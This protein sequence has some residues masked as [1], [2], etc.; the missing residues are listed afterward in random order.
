MNSSPKAE[1]PGEGAV[2][3]KHRPVCLWGAGSE[4]SRCCPGPELTA[5]SLRC[6]LCLQPEGKERRRAGQAAGDLLAPRGLQPVRLQSGDW[7]SLLSLSGVTSR[8]GGRVSLASLL[9]C[10]LRIQAQSRAY[11]GD[12]LLI[13]T[14]SGALGV[15]VHPSSNQKDKASSLPKEVARAVVPAVPSV[16]R[17]GARPSGGLLSTPVQ[18]GERGQEPWTPQPA[19][20]GQRALC[21]APQGPACLLPGWGGKQAGGRTGLLLEVAVPAAVAP[22]WPGRS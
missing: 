3:P 22:R 6:S 1:V 13:P 15:N 10:P 16:S 17:F 9:T 11:Q 20:R 7:L 14:A 4:G 19:H 5:A 12:F 21:P 8:T 2:G 18:A